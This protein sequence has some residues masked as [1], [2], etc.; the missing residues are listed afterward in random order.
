MLKVWKNIKY[1]IATQLF[2][3][4]QEILKLQDIA[5]RKGKLRFYADYIIAMISLYKRIILQE[6]R[7]LHYSGG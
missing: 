3:T 1:P 7:V 4:I 2:N 6:V 5:I